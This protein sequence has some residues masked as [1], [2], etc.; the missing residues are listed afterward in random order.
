MGTIRRRPQPQLE[1]G[2]P[3]LIFDLGLTDQTDL[4]DK[5]SGRSVTIPS[6]SFFFWDTSHQAWSAMGTSAIANSARISGL[7]LRALDGTP[8]F[9]TNQRHKT[10][11][12]EFECYPVSGSGS[13]YMLRHGPATGSMTGIFRS[14]S[15]PGVDFLTQR[16]WFRFK[17][18]MDIDNLTHTQYNDG[19]LAF[20]LAIAPN[21]L[22]TNAS[23]TSDEIHFTNTQWGD[24]S[25]G[26][27]L[28]FRNIKI[29]NKAIY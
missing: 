12:L 21:Q 3:A 13:I 14:Y 25:S 26:V 27:K 15:T 20:Q 8:L 7:D 11:T 19:N 10:H 18:I 28:L 23:T 17:K 6:T 16:K 29:Y 22:I 4:I 1:I 9:A 2:D 5:I 24:G